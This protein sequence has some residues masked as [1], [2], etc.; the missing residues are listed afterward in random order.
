[1][2]P[3]IGDLKE[4]ITEE[5]YAGEYFTSD[6][7]SEMA[8]AMKKLLVDNEHRIKIAKQNYVAANG[9]PM[10]DIADWFLMHFQRLANK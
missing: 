1:M 10:T 5:G 3:N 2:L 7:I 9:L 4:L 6:S 8:T